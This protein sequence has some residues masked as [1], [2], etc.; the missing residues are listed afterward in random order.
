VVDKDD[1]GGLGDRL[2]VERERADEASFD[3]ASPPGER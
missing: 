2:V 1:S 3:A